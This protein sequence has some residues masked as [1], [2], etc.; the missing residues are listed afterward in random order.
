[1]HAKRDNGV[2]DIEC[3]SADGRS[4]SPL[5]IRL[6]AIEEDW[7]R[8]AQPIRDS[9]TWFINWH[10]AV[11]RYFEHRHIT[12]CRVRRLITFKKEQSLQ[13]SLTSDVCA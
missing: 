1:M 9:S 3:V 13:A 6:V 5:I 8:V 10:A 4:L 7:L 12:R 11:L 2:T